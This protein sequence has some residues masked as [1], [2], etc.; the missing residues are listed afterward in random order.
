[1]PVLS[2]T[3]LSDARAHEAAGDFAS[4]DAI[5]RDL[6][7]PKAPDP[8]VLLAWSRLRRRVNDIDNA[9]T[10]LNLAGRAGGGVPVLIE[11]ASLAL[12]RNDT[13]Q[14]VPL[15][16]RAAG[17]GRTTALDYQVARCEFALGRHAQAAALFRDVVK[18]EP[19]NL[20]ARIGH[21]RCLLYAGKPHDAV[22]AFQAVL[23]RDPNNETALVDLA[24]LYGSLRRFPEALALYDRLEQNG[25]DVARELSQVALGLMH[26]CDWS[27]RDALRAR[28]AARVA[29]PHP[30]ITEAYA[31]FAADDDPV[32]HRQMAERFAGAILDFGAKREKPPARAVGPA[33]RRLRIGYLCGDF[34]QH[35]TSLLLAGVLEAHDRTKFEITAYDYSA[36]DGSPIRARVKAAFEHF[37]SLGTEGPAASAARI[38]ADDIDVLIDLKGYTERT[39]SEI[40]ALRPAPIQV[41]FLGYVGTQAGDWIDYVI[42][43]ADVLPDEEQVNWTEAAVHMPHSYYPNDRSRPR[44]EPLTGRAAQGLPEHG[45]V[46]TCFNNPF[47]IAPQIFA[48]W[49][50]VLKEVPDSVLWLYEN[51]EFVAGNLRATATSAGVDPAR[52]VFAKPAPLDQHLARHGCADLFLD[53]LPYGA[54]TTGADALWAGVPVVTC[55]GR[56]WAS[57]VG[58][59]L[60]HA[61]G[62]PELI[63]STLEEYKTLI[64]ALAADP[65]RR[66]A[67]R[68]RL[69]EARDTAPL[70]DEVAFARGLEAAYTTMAERSRAGE[71]PAAFKVQI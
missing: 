26:M 41:N 5:Y 28:L 47:K 43:D 31:F 18:A 49:M 30:C 65:A 24:H 8:T 23:Q 10:M 25:F 35:A 54:H 51:N 42:A 39:R 34:N 14:A 61:V 55:T 36:E 70:F 17:A 27:R 53:T 32:L 20:P 7:D 64:L 9:N 4:A 46:F 45:I 2:T 40:M 29:Q 66:A 3:R 58:A 48:I 67:L 62:L 1:M 69:L 56:S 68:A 44:P 22:G 12:D 37:V 38:A 21:A 13:D 50:E 11:M 57:R 16:R 63:T 52:L 71:K 33:G 6:Y 15:L 60:L 19:R 59:S